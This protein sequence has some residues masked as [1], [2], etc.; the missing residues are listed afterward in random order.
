VPVQEKGEKIMSLA[1]AMSLIAVVISL[2]SITVLART[3]IG[4]NKFR[5]GIEADIHEKIVENHKANLIR[6]DPDAR[7]L[8][9]LGADIDDIEFERMAQEI[10]K[11]LDIEGAKTKVVI[12]NSNLTLL[13]F[14]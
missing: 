13:K 14:D 3:I 9:S 2:A 10:N 4:W 1:L 5:S 12:T 8:V 11:H 7:Y 6:L